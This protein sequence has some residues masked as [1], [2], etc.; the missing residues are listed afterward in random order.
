M[1]GSDEPKRI[2]IDERT[3]A[4]ARSQSSADAENRLRASV[5]RF[6]GPHNRLHSPEAMARMEATVLSTFLES[7]WPAQK[8]EY[9][10]ERVEGA[11]DYGEGV[12]V[13]FRELS[14][15]NVIAVRRGEEFPQD[16]IVVVAHYD[17]RP[18]TP[19]ADD[20]TAGVVAL[21][22]LARILPTHGWKRTVILAA[23]DME[24]LLCVGARALVPELTQS[25]RIL[26]AINLETMAYTTKKSHTFGFESKPGIL[27]RR[28]WERMRRADWASKFT[29][30]LYQ[31]S[32]AT[33]ASTFASALE[34]FAGPEA[35]VLARDPGD[36]PVLG[37]F[38][39]RIAPN[40][41]RQF[42]R[43]DHMVFWNAG[44]PAIQITDGANFGNP[45]YH[46]ASD[47]PE[48]LDYSRLA[49]VILAVACT[50]AMVVRF[51]PT[52]GK[53]ATS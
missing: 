12:P 27:Y 37:F 53:V 49:A 6:L 9:K 11:L 48:T 17:T 34:L 19:G 10:L 44:I 46:R 21:L 7:G 30:G 16:A 24:E 25:Y 32:S 23:T 14:G 2:S 1:F 47:L 40:L 39:R 51:H 20:N 15:A 38:I 5:S 43:S 45:N 26:G 50:I 8:Q 41:V 31:G 36:L 18:D 3:Q 29:L 35:C 13:C 22:E 52:E 42:H 4:W 28:Q 33:L